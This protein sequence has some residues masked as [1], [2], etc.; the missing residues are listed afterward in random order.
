[1][2]VSGLA[3]MGLGAG[4]ALAGGSEGSIGV[5]AEYQLSG[6]G[7]LSG[8]YD[9]GQFHVGGFL[10]FQDGGGTDD[11]DIDLGARFYY[12]V[13]STP[14]SDFGVGGSFGLRFDA[15]GNANTDNATLLFIEPGL[16]IRAFVASNVALSFTAGLS[17]GLIDANGVSIGGAPVGG[18]GVHYYFF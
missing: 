12:H 14:Q 7:S 6:L 18:A 10:G 3:V 17:L 11:T 16:Q 5:G 15:D 8:S 13:H 2:L 4:T 1:M 9:V